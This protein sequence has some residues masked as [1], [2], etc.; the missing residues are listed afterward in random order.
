MAE[1]SRGA[2]PT[3][4]STASSLQGGP[5]RHAKSW[6]NT[7]RQQAAPFPGLTIPKP[8][9]WE[10]VLRH[11]MEPDPPLKLHTALKDWPRDWY[12]GVNRPLNQLYC[13]RRMVAREYFDE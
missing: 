1:G 8:Q 2:T 12:N 3:T 4:S 9:S 13:Q 5:T 6:A 11:W 10:D 7:R